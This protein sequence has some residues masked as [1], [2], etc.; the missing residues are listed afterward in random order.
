M[1]KPPESPRPPTHVDW[2]AGF[3]SYLVPGLGQIVRGRVAKGLMFLVILHG[4][5][6]YGMHLGQWSNVYL[7]HEPV[8]GNSFLF[9]QGAKGVGPALFMRL[10]FLAQFWMGVASWPAIYHYAMHTRSLT[11]ADPPPSTPAEF[12]ANFQRPWTEDRINDYQRDADKFWDLG[13]IYTIIAGAL[14]LLVIYDAAAGPAFA[15]HG[16]PPAKKDDAK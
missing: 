7:T 15:P 2:F 8:P 12:V 11:S 3:L 1:A 10:P 13:S 4:M 16:T 9:R 6:F 14:S 5:F